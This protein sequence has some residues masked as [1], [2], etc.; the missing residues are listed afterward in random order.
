MGLQTT[1]GQILLVFGSVHRV[2][3]GAT[4]KKVLTLG[5]GPKV[6]RMRELGNIDQIIQW[7]IS[8]YSLL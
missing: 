8:D 5:L 7:V 2:K 1:H 6:G 3:R 4:I